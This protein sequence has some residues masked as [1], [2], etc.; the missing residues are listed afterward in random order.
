MEL[1]KLI[2]ILAASAEAIEGSS[3]TKNFRAEVAAQAADPRMLLV[4]FLFR[5]PG[6][7]E[8]DHGR[9]SLSSSGVMG[10]PSLSTSTRMQRDKATDMPVRSVAAKKL[11][12]EK[13]RFY[14][15]FRPTEKRQINYTYA[16]Y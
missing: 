15:A 3:R 14:E 9:Y 16:M 2:V 12:R 4:H 10:F 11:M 13:S 7:L 1:E 5:E 6:L 8:L